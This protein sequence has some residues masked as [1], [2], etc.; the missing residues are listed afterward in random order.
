MT[1]PLR[2]RDVR[3][4]FGHTQ[5]P[6]KGA[7]LSFGGTDLPENLA[8]LVEGVHVTFNVEVE[9]RARRCRRGSRRSGAHRQ[10]RRAC[11]GVTAR[12][13]VTG[14]SKG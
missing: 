8:A 14:R 6:P 13:F 9:E 2:V 3:M 11:S 1:S 5:I 4:N 12:C 10:W 7:V